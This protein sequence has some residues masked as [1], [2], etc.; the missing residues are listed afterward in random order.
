V[1]AL[2]VTDALWSVAAVRGG[3]RWPNDV[4]A[5]GR[6]ICGILP[7]AVCE[8]DGR[9]RHVILGVGI[10]VNQAA[11]PAELADRATSLR[12]LTGRVH[13]PA[14]LGTGVLAALD[15]WYGRWRGGGFAPLRDEWR[16]RAITIGARVRLPGG[17]D[18]VAVDVAED[19]ALLVD[20]GGDALT[21]VV[22]ATLGAEPGREG[23]RGAPRH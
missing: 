10:N 1:A 11:F 13:E 7:E 21:R 9:V 2:A 19:G 8:A 5:G 14:A 22:S 3:I 4:L 6:K 23:E 18:G 17:G 16:R 12:L 15:R 20:A